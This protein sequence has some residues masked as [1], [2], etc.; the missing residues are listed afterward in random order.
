MAKVWEECP[1]FNLPEISASSTQMSKTMSVW[2]I[3]LSI[4]QQ[5]P[6]HAVAFGI[7]LSSDVQGYLAHKKVPPPR[8]LHAV[9]VRVLVRDYRGVPLSEGAGILKNARH[10]SFLI[11]RKR[12]GYARLPFLSLKEVHTKRSLRFL[13]LRSR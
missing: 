10:L 9:T 12:S 13:I 5:R 11:A 4:Y 1:R 2:S 7:L 6:P 8:T 3:W